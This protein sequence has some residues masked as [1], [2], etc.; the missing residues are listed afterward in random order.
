MEFPYWFIPIC[1]Y[2]YHLLLLSYVLLFLSY[3]SYN[4]IFGSIDILVDIAITSSTSSTTIFTIIYTI[5]I[6]IIVILYYIIY[7]YIHN[8]ILYVFIFRIY[9]LY[10]S[11][12]RYY[13]GFAA[14]R[15]KKILGIFTFGKAF[16]IW[17]AYKK[18]RKIK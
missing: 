8:K 18:H 17:N 14:R 15:K 6:F 11:P 16:M 3:Y 12:L 2:P 4:I 9:V 7:I 13:R 5:Y 1:D 10:I